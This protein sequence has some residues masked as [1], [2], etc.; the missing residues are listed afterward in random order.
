VCYVP[1][2]LNYLLTYFMQQS[3]SWEAN[4]FEASQEIAAFL[5][6]PKVLYR[7]HKCP[8]SVPSQSQLNP[9][10]T[11]HLTSWRFI[12]ILSALQ[13][14]GLPIGTFPSGF[15][16]KPCTRLSPPTSEVHAT[17]ILFFLILSPVKYLVRNTYHGVPFYLVCCVSYQ[18]KNSSVNP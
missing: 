10:H 7:T 14:L 16:P 8:P 18:N 11:P 15:P 2:I 12:L 17:H 1:Y 5:W 13:N 9:V 3:P 4:R 6:N